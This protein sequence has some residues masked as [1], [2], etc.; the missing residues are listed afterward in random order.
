M[1]SDEGGRRRP[2]ASPAITRLALV[3]AATLAL[4]GC[5]TTVRASPGT[6]APPPPA[7]PAAASPPVAPIAPAVPVPAATGPAAAPLFEPIGWAVLPAADQR[8]RGTVVGGLSGLAY[9]PGSGRYRAVSDDRR[10]P[11]FYTL[12]IDLGG[13]RLDADGVRVEA[14]TFLA[15]GGGR[16]FADGRADLE[17]I[18]PAPGGGLF[19][20][21]EGD[22]A[23]GAAPFVARFDLDGRLLG[24]LPVP[25]YYLPAPATGSGVRDNKAF[26]ALTVTP[27]GSRLVAGLENA[28][29]QDGPAADLG[30]GSPARLLIYDLATGVP[31]SERVYPVDPVELAPSPAD[32]FRLNGLVELAALDNGRLLALERGF[33]AG[34]GLTVAAGTSVR[35]YL[36]T[37][38]EGTELALRPRLAEAPGGGPPRPVGKRLLLDLGAAGLPLDNLEGM[39]LGPLLPDGRR[40]LVLVA[41]DNFKPLVQ[42]TLFLAF[43]FDPAALA[44]TAG[45]ADAAG[46]PPGETP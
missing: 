41:D 23:H 44:A 9:D 34:R 30:V 40:S 10:R 26:E 46:E 45:A 18:A 11:R 14:V 36:V 33:S 15:D 32:A 2:P 35:L 17:G 19:L 13:G 7:L 22:T 43:A 25:A 5:R 37:L 31:V 8:F 21:S 20:A 16:P 42:R 38:A 27:D 24:E 29:T 12:A 39:T 4:A 3:L 1:R 6:P 28:L